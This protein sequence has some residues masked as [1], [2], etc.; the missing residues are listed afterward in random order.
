M[1]SSGYEPLFQTCWQRAIS[2]IVSGRAEAIETHKTEVIKTIAGDIPLPTKVRFI[3]GF[4]AAKLRKLNTGAR[5]NKRAIFSRDE[6]LCQYCQ[7][8]TAYSHGTIEHIMP[9]SKG[10]THT[11]CNVVWACEKCNQKKGDKLLEDTGFE[12]KKLPQKPT[13]LELFKHNVKR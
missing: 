4:I 6:G 3:S 11:W 10:G 8:Y 12:L 5:L 2:A 13:M 7:K 9:R 1:L